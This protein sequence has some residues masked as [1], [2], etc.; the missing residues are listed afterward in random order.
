M[1]PI[2][3]LFVMAILA[4][5]L[6]GLSACSSTNNR[7]SDSDVTDRPVVG[8]EKTE[9]YAEQPVSVE[10]KTVDP[11]TGTKDT[12]N[13]AGKHPIADEQTAGEKMSNDMNPQQQNN[14]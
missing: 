1:K 14:P 7:T 8:S 5:S 9:K 6:V 3:S 2:K 4:G 10:K 12:E 11:Y 13:F